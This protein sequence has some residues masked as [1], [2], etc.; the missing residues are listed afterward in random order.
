MIS[1]TISSPQTNPRV[2]SVGAVD[3]ARSADPN[4]PSKIDTFAPADVR[5]PRT[6]KHTVAIIDTG[7]DPH[8]DFRDR[9]VGWKDLVNG[10]PEPYD[11]VGSGTMVA[12]LIA[13]NGQAS[14]GKYV[15]VLPEANLVGI[16]VLDAHGK[17]VA[18]TQWA[19]KADDGNIIAGIQW[20]VDHKDEYGIDVINV[21]LRSPENDPPL[22]KAIEA[23]LK[24]GIITVMASPSHTDDALQGERVVSPS[25]RPDIVAP[26][27][28]LQP[29]ADR[30][31]GRLPLRPT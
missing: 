28:A 25:L 20:A 14:G 21:S 2:I 15:G 1:K 16:K 9:I 4:S 31:P 29:P 8:A 10:R 6:G 27:I 7:L 30:Y 5:P 24:K 17:A 22:E 19:G 12:G 11:D 26:G 18:G 3:A 23:A 13:G